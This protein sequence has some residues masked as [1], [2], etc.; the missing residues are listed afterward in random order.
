VQ[1]L[2]RL[3]VYRLRKKVY[4]SSRN[5][6]DAEETMTGHREQKASGISAGPNLGI[7]E[8][9]NY[10]QSL[11]S[12]P[13]AN[14]YGWSPPNTYPS[15]IE[16]FRQN[17][18]ATEIYFIESGIVKLSHIGPGGKEVII[19]LRR[20]NWLLGVTQVCVAEDYSTTATTLTRCTMRH[21][22]A[23]EFLGQLTMDIALSVEL[24]RMLSRE[25]RS[26]IEKIITLGSMSATE[27]LRSFL[28]ELISEEDPAELEKKGRLELPLRSD[29]LA[30]IVAVTPQHLYRLL[31]DPELR[32]HIKQSK[33]ILTIVDPLIFL[34]NDSSES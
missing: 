2:P 24:N 21:I 34:H 1:S 26:N 4:I 23:R 10:F 3:P 9:A 29:E 33:R 32:T 22:S 17:D 27:R 8:T 30:E 14:V 7:C 28:H 19:S 15:G 6:Q 16:L 13:D 31:K 18:P 12:T 20:R 11:F 25:I 5:R